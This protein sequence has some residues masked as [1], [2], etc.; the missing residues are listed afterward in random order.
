MTE[1][2]VR[3]VARATTLVAA[4]VALTLSGGAPSWTEQLQPKPGTPVV[5]PSEAGET[6]AP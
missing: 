3:L 2:L 5:A 4:T 6:T 1:S